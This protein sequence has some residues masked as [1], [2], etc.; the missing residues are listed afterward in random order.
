MRR[1]QLVAAA[2]AL[3]GAAMAQATA[4]AP[5]R[6]GRQATFVLQHGA[7]HG[8]WCWRRVADRLQALGHR[9]VTPTSTGLG[10]RAH[11]I[12]SMVTL[13]VFVT[14]LVNA[15]ESQ[16]LEDIVLVGHSFGGLAISG[17]A[18]RLAKRIRHLVYLDSVILQPGQSVLGSLRPEVAA[19][20][21][22]SI[23]AGGGISLPP[24][25]ASFF[26]IG[27]PSDVAWLQRRLTPHPAGTYDSPL[28]L[29]N[30]VGNGL[31]RT[32]IACTRDALASIEPMRQ[33]VRQ[34][35]GWR[36]EEMAEVHN[37][38]MTAPDTLTRRLLDIAG[39]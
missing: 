3:P 29:A 31:P 4:P 21:R 37:V 36:Y 24:P 33:W 22:E 18:D 30:Q 10:E 14:D 38:M 1:R 5:A 25:P 12:S 35:P 39:V 23:R 9:V 8:G 6:T 7:W 11:L 32:Y 13:E 17:A 26:G 27:D 28:T 15:I 19:A 2:A 16:E 20:R 34:Q